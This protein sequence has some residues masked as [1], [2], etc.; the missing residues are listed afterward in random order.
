VSLLNILVIVLIDGPKY[1]NVVHLL[2]ISWCYSVSDVGPLI[3]LLT[4]V[5]N[6][7]LVAFVL[8]IFSS[9]SLM[10]FDMDND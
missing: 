8:I 9:F 4:V 2:S 7:F 3:V 10:S 6:H 5:C 1:V